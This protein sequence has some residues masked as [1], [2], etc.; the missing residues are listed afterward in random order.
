M[1]AGLH[2]EGLGLGFAGGAVHDPLAALLFCASPQ[3][4][5][6]VVDG[7]V[8]VREGQLATVELGPL[9]ERHNKL[10]RELAGAG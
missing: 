4:A 6:T 10:A 5:W 1:L 3:A 2:D 9:V 8:V 7:R